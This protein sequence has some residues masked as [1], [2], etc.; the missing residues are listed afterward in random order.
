MDLKREDKR[1]PVDSKSVDKRTDYLLF[2]FH[3]QGNLN[4]R[5]DEV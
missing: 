3:I 4:E 2:F 5:H 1:V